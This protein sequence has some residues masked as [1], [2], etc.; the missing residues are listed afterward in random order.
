MRR[1][2]GRSG[3]IPKITSNIIQLTL[4][5]RNE[6]G[7]EYGKLTTIIDGK[8]YMIKDKVE[9]DKEFLLGFTVNGSGSNVECKISSDCE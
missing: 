2:G 6:N 7:E 1:E 8:E 4:D 3:R 9:M 5:M